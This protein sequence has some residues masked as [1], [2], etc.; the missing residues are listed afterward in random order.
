MRRC[1]AQVPG[2]DDEVDEETMEEL[3]ALIE[4]DYEVRCLC[5]P[6]G[7]VGCREGAGA[8]LCE[9]RKL[10]RRFKKGS[11]VHEDQGQVQ[12]TGNGLWT[13]GKGGH[14]RRREQGAAKAVR[15]CGVP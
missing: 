12:A 8:A 14:G 15:H 5:T 9:S 10:P 6:D 2:E 1:A 4:A 11:D 13:A 3:Q 7:L